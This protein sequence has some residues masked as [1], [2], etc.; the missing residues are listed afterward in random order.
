VSDLS[1][2]LTM[3]FAKH[4]SST[5]FDS[6][7]I[8]TAFFLEPES[9]EAM[10]RDTERLERNLYRGD[11]MEYASIRGTKKLDPVTMTLLG[12]GVN[13]NTG[14]SAFAAAEYT[15]LGQLL[16][17]VI[18][19]STDPTSSGESA[20]GGTGSSSQ[21]TFAS[22]TNYPA[23]CGVLFANTSGQVFA[24]AIVSAAEPPTTVTLDRDFTGTAAAA[25]V[26]RGARWSLD[27][28]TSMHTHAY[29]Q[30]EGEN[31]RRNYSG[32][33]SGLDIDMPE[34]QPVKF[35]FSWQPTDWSDSA[36][37]NGSFTAPTAGDFIVNVGGLFYIGNS[38]FLLKEAKLS[39][40]YTIVARATQA[41]QNGVLGY[42]VTRKMPV[43]SGKLY[44]GVNAS[45]GE[46]ADSSGTPSLNSMQGVDVNPGVVVTTRDI[47]L[48]VGTGGATTAATA[49]GR[50]MYMRMPAAEFRAKLAAENGQEV[51]QFE[52]H[53]RRPSSGSPFELFMF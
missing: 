9:C 53:A 15:E 16:D 33:M 36:E 5:V 51:I 21:L 35:N 31:W 17:C 11:N 24:R 47:S 14:T 30:A 37:A 20:T 44:M 40:G 29:L 34:G 1:R 43:L 45:L 18:G 28:A 3:K 38:A 25:T 13:G 42:V 7:S 4:S 8:G 32:C 2:M 52:A 23:G 46:I 48:Q 22:G 49:G 50:S 27:P 26:V 19:A 39:L 10:P 6:A 12:R 41:G